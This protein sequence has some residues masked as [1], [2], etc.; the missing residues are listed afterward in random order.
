MSEDDERS[1]EY[2]R[3]EHAGMGLAE[4]FLLQAI[5]SVLAD[6]SR[7]PEAF[8][9]LLRRVALERLEPLLNESSMGPEFLAGL[10]EFVSGQIEIIT[11]DLDAAAREP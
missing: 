8:R 4:R 5:I 10:G 2:R 11:M 7:D 9:D 6:H 1:S 3:G